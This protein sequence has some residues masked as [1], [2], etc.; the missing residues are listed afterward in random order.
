MIRP[1]DRASPATS[2]RPGRGPVY[3]VIIPTACVLVSGWVNRW[4]SD[5]ALITF[6]VARQIAAGHGPVF[7]LGE[8]AEAST[9]PLWT[10]LLAGL[11]AGLPGDVAW[12]AVLAGLVLSALAVALTTAT[13]LRIHGPG[14]VFPFGVVMVLAIPAFWDYFT[15]GMETGLSFAWLAVC[16][17]VLVRTASGSETEDSSTARH[18]YG[19]LLMGLGPLVRP[20]FFIVTAV[21]TLGYLLLIHKSRAEDLRLLGLTAVTPVIYEVFRAGYYGVLVPNTALAKEATSSNW[22]QGL[23]YLYDFSAAYQVWLPLGLLMTAVSGFAMSHPTREALV[24]RLCPL[25]SGVLLTLYVVRVGGDFMHARLL[26]PAIWL[27]AMS[28]W[29]WRLTTRAVTAVVVGECV[30]GLICALYLRVSYGPQAYFHGITDERR[31][32]ASRTAADHPVTLAD[33][34][35]SADT[36][37]AELVADESAHPG[38]IWYFTLDALDRVRSAPLAAQAPPSVAAFIFGQTGLAL[39][40]N[41][42][43]IDLRG[44]ADPVTA[45]QRLRHRGRP[46][47]EKWLEEDD[48]LSRFAAPGTLGARRP[49]W[50]DVERSCP[51]LGQLA[52]ATAS[53]LTVQRFL[54]NILGSPALTVYRF[55]P[56]T[57]LEVGKSC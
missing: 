23:W 37:T 5:D 35:A 9:S 48:L 25:A 49:T 36:P 3:F 6:R 7:N 45:H 20:E 13:S 32:W 15:S 22:R 16:W 18:R 28:M 52:A 24:S 57:D 30:W 43:V 44:L 12:L 39:P 34:L 38:Y 21:F 29:T 56:S 2:R 11:D 31:Y 27:I 50:A 4:T 8:R 26:L 47:H 33:H 51:M 42:R 54:K 14:V 1:V 55:E 19:A 46:G 41:A 40:L 17:S 53:R 10:W